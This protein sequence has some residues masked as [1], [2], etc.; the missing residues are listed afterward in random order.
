MKTGGQLQAVEDVW[1]QNSKFVNILTKEAML[2][3]VE[4]LSLT[5]H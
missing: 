2:K 4:L 5:G 1:H 3:T